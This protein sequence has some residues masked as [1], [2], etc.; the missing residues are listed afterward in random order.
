VILKS[1]RCCEECRYFGPCSE[2]LDKM[3]K[4]PPIPQATSVDPVSIIVRSWIRWF[5][6]AVGLAGLGFVVWAITQV[7]FIGRYHDAL[8]RMDNRVK[9]LEKELVETKSAYWGEYYYRQC[10]GHWGDEIRHAESE[11]QSDH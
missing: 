6:L 3:D 10:M 9:V 2:C 11:Q 5:P 7:I 1:V 8:G 4:Q